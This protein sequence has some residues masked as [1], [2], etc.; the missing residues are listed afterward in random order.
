MEGLNE[1]LRAGRAGFETDDV[2]N[3]TGTVHG[4]F[5]DSCERNVDSFR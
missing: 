2:E 4:T 1:V 3:I 5:H